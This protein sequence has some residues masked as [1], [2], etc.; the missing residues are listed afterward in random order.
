[1]YW[2]EPSGSPATS[3]SSA[4]DHRVREQSLGR[5]EG[6]V[7]DG[8]D[9]GSR[10][11]RLLEDQGPQL[12]PQTPRLLSTTPLGC[13]RW[14]GYGLASSWVCTRQHGPQRRGVPAS[15]DWSMGCRVPG[16]PSLG[17]GTMPSSWHMSSYTWMLSKGSTSRP[18]LKLGPTARKMVFISMSW[19]SKPCSPL[20]NWTFT[21]CGEEQGFWVTSG[22]HAVPSTSL[23]VFPCSPMGWHLCEWMTLGKV[24]HVW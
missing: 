5:A 2:P 13:V 8:Q 15:P 17:S 6:S 18:A 12:S 20:L 16:S 7:R 1:M 21:L 9:C 19:L 4:G 23:P 3:S 24:Y 11:H 10:L 22:D 14:P